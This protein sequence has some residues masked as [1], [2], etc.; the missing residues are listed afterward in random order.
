MFA[1][2]N[3]GNTIAPGEKMLTL[4]ASLESPNCDGTLDLINDHPVSQLCSYCATILSNGFDAV[5]NEAEIEEG[6]TKLNVHC[7]EQGIVFDLHCSDGVSWS[8]SPLFNWELVFQLLLAVCPDLFG[9]VRE[10]LHHVFLDN[11]EFLGYPTSD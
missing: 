6:K 7:S 2:T 5:V 9:D 1:C 4:V 10:P 11:L 3:C 8:P